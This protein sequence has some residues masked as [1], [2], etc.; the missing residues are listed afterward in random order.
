MKDKNKPWVL[1]I[2]SSHNGA[3]CLLRGDEIVVAIQEERLLRR[4]R[5]EHPHWKPSLALKYC[6]DTAGIRPEDLSA[7]AV[8]STGPARTPAEDV[9]LNQF[10]RPQDNKIPIFRVG[11]HLSHAVGAFA[12]SWFKE[13][14]VI[15]IDGSCSPIADVDEKEL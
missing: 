4:K 9:S 12:T 13:S 15:V 3:V 7:I 14:A 10:L 2:A 1:G 8:N 11:H 6:F 5:A